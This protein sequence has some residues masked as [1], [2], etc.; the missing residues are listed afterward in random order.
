MAVLGFVG[1]AGLVGFKY[2]SLKSDQAR[3]TSLQQQTQDESAV[4][5]QLTRS[6]QDLEGAR[7][8]LTHLEQGIPSTAYI[9]T[10]LQE[11]EKTGRSCGISVTGVRPVPKAVAASNTA[12]ASDGSEA[13]Q[14]PAYDEISI[15]VKGRGNYA[16]VR[17]FVKA[18]ET[19]PKI[20]GAHTIDIVPC[21]EP[22]DAM[23]G[24]VDITV[25]LHAYLFTDTTKKPSDAASDVGGASSAAGAKAP[26]PSDKANA[27]S[28]PKSVASQKGKEASA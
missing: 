7:A 6:Q 13:I 25:G 20:V 24:L 23:Q 4:Q 28:T 22:K 2:S 16:S 14:K 5:E 12:Q 27:S 10:M 3:V 1:G 26:A 17:K 8:S 18:L 19:F 9:P 11:L 21:L 15:E